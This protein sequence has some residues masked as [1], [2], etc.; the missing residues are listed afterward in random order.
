MLILGALFSVSKCE[1]ETLGYLNFAQ[2]ASHAPNAYFYWKGRQQQVS[3]HHI[4]YCVVSHVRQVLVEHGTCV[5]CAGTGTTGGLCLN[6]A[7]FSQN[8]HKGA[9]CLAQVVPYWYI[10]I[11][12]QFLSSMRFD[13]INVCQNEIE[14]EICV[15]IKEF[16]DIDAT[17]QWRVP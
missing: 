5:L 14:F 16:R 1:R 11:W 8:G 2:P 17:M 12:S 7:F 3:T 6:A 15:C 13:E 4:G 10:V 9:S